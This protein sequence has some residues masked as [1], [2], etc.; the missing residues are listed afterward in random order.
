MEMANIILW[1][2]AMLT[3]DV[4]QDWLATDLQQIADFMFGQ[5]DE[6]RL[7]Q[8]Q[9]VALTSAANEDAHQHGVRRRPASILLT[10][11]AAREDEPL[12]HKRYHES[13]GSQGIR[14]LVMPVPSEAT[15]QLA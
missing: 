2:R 15:A 8:L 10:R 9:Q 5:V 3:D 7:W 4:A 1:H 6:L 11:E 12:L 13:G 14:D